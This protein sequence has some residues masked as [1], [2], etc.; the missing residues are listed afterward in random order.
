MI[1]S[2]QLKIHSWFIV[3]TIYKPFGND[4]HQVLITCIIFRQ[5]HQMIVSVLS[6]SAFP[7]KTGAG[8]HINLTAK[9]RLDPHFPGSPVKIDD[10]VHNAVIGDC[11]AVHSQLF[12]PC[13]QLLNLGRAI[14]KAV[15]CM[16]M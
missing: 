8:S 7:V 1:R 16:D 11:H 6:C 13:S 3:K 9:D 2:K 4:L 12:C 5:Q 14:Q 15:F 10:A